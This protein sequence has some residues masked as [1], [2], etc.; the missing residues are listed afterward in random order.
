MESLV[1]ILEAYFQDIV[2][3]VTKLDSDNKGTTVLGS[4]PGR[5]I[6]EDEEIE[7]DRICEDT[8][9]KWL[10][11]SGYRIDLYSEHSIREIGNYDAQTQYLVTCDPFDGSG[12]FSR[13]IPSGWWSVLTIWDA[14]GFQP[15]LAGAIDIIRREMY[16]A[17]SGKVYLKSFDTGK[18]EV[19]F[20]SDEKG[21]SNNLVIAAYLMNPDYLS[22]WV[23]KGSRLIHIM[24]D[25]FPKARLWAD[26]GSCIYPWLSRGVIDAYVMFEE[27]RSEIDPGLGFAWASRYPVY[28]VQKNGDVTNYR[29]EPGNGSKRIPWLVSACTE[30]LAQGIIEVLIGR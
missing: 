20:R 23:D 9:Q 4:V 26:G 22:N 18:S 15:V 29:F 28:I 7:L 24:K 19:I 25:K 27:P 14:A 8:L 12:H 5:P 11:T 10:E 21:L 1:A 2:S 6:V 13:G 3:I 16:I 30:E 17:Q